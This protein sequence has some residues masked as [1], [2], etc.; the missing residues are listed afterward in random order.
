MSAKNLPRPIGILFEYSA[1]LIVGSLLAL[2]WANINY[3]SYHGFVHHDLISNL[4][5]S[6]IHFVVNDIFMVFFFGIAMKEVTEAFLP[7]GSLSSFDKAALP[8]IGT[9]GGVVGPATLFVVLALLFKQGHAQTAMLHGWAIPTATD[10]AYSWLFAKIVFGASHPAVTFLLVLAVLDDLIGMGIIAIFY[11]SDIKVMYLGLLALGMAMAFGLRKM[12]VKNFWPYV[13]LGGIPAWF[14]LLYTGVH[15]SLALVFIVPFMPAAID[16]EDKFFDSEE[17]EEEHDTLNAFEHFFKSPV[18]IGLFFFGLA[19]AGVPAEAAGLGTAITIS[20]IFF[21]KTFGIF[22]FSMIGNKVFKMAFPDHTGYKELFVLGVVAAIGFTVAIFVT[23]VAFGEPPAA[24]KGEEFKGIL[25]AYE[26]E[27]KM[28]ALL[29]FLSGF[30]A[31]VL[32]KVLKIK[33]VE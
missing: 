16:G 2:F 20:S 7:G 23:T 15:S 31:L 24:L 1:F 3:D 28:G 27:M 25:I 21:G 11:S 6:S 19:N 10:I 29:S 17:M 8:V 26:K 13:L 18:D 33:K 12:N 9:I 32:G 5:H 30:T 14:G 4:K 22:L